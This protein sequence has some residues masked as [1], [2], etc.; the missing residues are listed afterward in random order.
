[1][2]ADYHSRIGKN[3][4]FDATANRVAYGRSNREYTADAA[5]IRSK[6]N[7]VDEVG[8]EKEED[9]RGIVCYQA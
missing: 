3:L 1:M 4:G 7:A 9:G 5:N 6:G 8:V 2:G